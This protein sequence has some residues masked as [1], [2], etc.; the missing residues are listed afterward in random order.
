MGTL[1]VFY[2]AWRPSSSASGESQRK[3]EEKKKKELETAA[4]DHE[5]WAENFY[6]L[7]LRS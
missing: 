1:C 4:V 5:G 6:Y 3:K 7:L 2:C